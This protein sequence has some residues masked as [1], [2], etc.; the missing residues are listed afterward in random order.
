MAHTKTPWHAGASSPDIVYSEEGIM[1]CE[2]WT[3][4]VSC[5][6]TEANAAFIVIAVNNHEKNISLIKRLSH[7]IDLDIEI[8]GK[9]TWPEQLINDVKES[10]K[11]AKHKKH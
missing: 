1:M 4:G 9:S 7:Q 10:I 6:V 2:C 5:K 3:M 11:A 8:N